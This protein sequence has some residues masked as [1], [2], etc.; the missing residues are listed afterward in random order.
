MFE[1]KCLLEDRGSKYH[2][3][4]VEA[5]PFAMDE[6]EQP[7][8]K[9]R[10]LIPNIRLRVNKVQFQGKM[11]AKRNFFFSLIEKECDALRYAESQ[12]RNF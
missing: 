3:A 2:E 12:E 9:G 8:D 1:Q 6:I 11:E 5:L 4:Q 7:E 10:E